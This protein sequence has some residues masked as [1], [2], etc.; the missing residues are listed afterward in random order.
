LERSW[1]IIT[2]LLLANLI[3]A[4]R[5]DFA[6]STSILVSP[7]KPGVSQIHP[8]FRGSGK[9]YQAASF[10]T[11]EIGS[12]SEVLGNV[13][14]PDRVQF[15]WKY[16]IVATVFWIGEP[17]VIGNLVSNSESAWDPAWVMRYGGD[18]DPLLRINFLPLGFVPKQNPFYVALPYNDVEE[19]HTFRSRDGHS[20]V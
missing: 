10:L 17:P 11:N 14:R 3:L 15:A 1:T 9:R 12:Q 5:S 8:I 4:A 20:L 13:T 16:K 19:D 18:D 7:G 2:S 6:Q